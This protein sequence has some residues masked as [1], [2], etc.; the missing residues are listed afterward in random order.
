MEHTIDN[1]FIINDEETFKQY[2]YKVVEECDLKQSNF[3]FP[4]ARFENWPTLHFNVKGGSKYNAT[5]TSYLVEGLK[6]FTD[7]IFRAICV[8]KYGKPD[9]R[10]LKEKD[11]EEF[12]L[13]IKIAEGSS[14]GE[15][16]ADK[17]ANS[18]FTNMN[19]TLKS[20][21]G[22]KQLIAFI[23]YIGVLGGVSSFGLAQYFQMQIEETK[24]QVAIAGKLSDNTKEMLAEQAKAFVDINKQNQESIQEL[25]EKI[26]ADNKTTFSEELEKRGELASESFMKQIAKDPA[27]TEVSVQS[28]TAKGKELE[29]YKQRAMAEKSTNNNTND[30]YIKG[31]ERTGPLGNILSITA[32]RTDGITLT[33]KVKIEKLQDFEKNILSNEVVK[34]EDER[35]LIRLTYKETW[36][37][38]QKSGAG[39]LISVAFKDINN[40]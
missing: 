11:R 5:V 13:V 3:V 32:Q 17:I 15:G 22:W 7:E 1:V 14:D 24:A 9:L 19:D 21:T 29:Q 20:M 40:N 38:G 34:K 25:M 8:V 18:F 28:I 35:H 23:T 27:V 6:D 10:Y 33:L 2:I 30:F 39:E 16:S 4:A 26:I 36:R 12:D 37:N 31:L